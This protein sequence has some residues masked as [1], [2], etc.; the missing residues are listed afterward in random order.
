MR[1]DFSDEMIGETLGGLSESDDIIGGIIKQAKK[2][3]SIIRRVIGP[4][5]E[6]KRSLLLR[7]FLELDSIYF[8]W[9]CAPH[10]EIVQYIWP[11][12]GEFFQYEVNRGYQKDLAIFDNS[13]TIDGRKLTSALDTGITS[14]ARIWFTLTSEDPN[15]MDDPGVADYCHT[16]QTILFAIIAKS[17]FYKANRNVLDDV[18][19]IATGAMLVEADKEDVFRCTHLPPGSYRCSTDSRGR[20]NR[21]VRRFTLTASQMIQEFGAENCSQSVQQSFLN[22][23]VQ[24]PYQVIQVIEPRIERDP[25]KADARNKPWAS[26]WLEIGAGTWGANSVPG[27]G[28][29]NPSAMGPE[30][31]LRES[32][33]DIQPMVV[34]RWNAIGTDAYGKDSPGWICLSDVKALQGLMV[35][36]SSTIARIGEPPLTVPDELKNASLL[37]GA[38]NHVK[39]GAHNAKVEPTIMIPPDAVRVM[40]EEKQEHRQRISA[41]NYGDVL[42]LIS[43]GGDAKEP[44]TAEEIRGKKAEQLLQLGGVFS[45]LSDEYL[46]PAIAAMFHHAQLAGKFPRPPPNLAKKGKLKIVFQNPLVTA[47]KTLEFSA[48]QQGLSMAQACAEAKQAGVDQWDFDEVNREA[49]SMLGLNPKLLKQADQL[50]Q[51]RQQ[52]AQQQ[53]MQNQAAALKAGGPAV[54]QLADANPDRMN[55]LLAQLGPNAQAQGGQP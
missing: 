34:P 5:E 16:V 12:R 38:I 22:G 7:R 40:Q 24:I 48:I 14:E 41:A 29:L 49:N 27:V 23:M 53:S 18:V 21:L 30:G 42:F 3:R 1:D 50:A 26:Y 17:N 15:D 9:W 25:D 28:D 20:V 4:E 35:M 43:N 19:G 36:G 2:S 6:E 8:T 32:G 37:P 39:A 10:I 55:Q 51:E 11:N 47:Q 52:V 44:A 33:Y 46:K 31:L 13:A 54:A 45:R